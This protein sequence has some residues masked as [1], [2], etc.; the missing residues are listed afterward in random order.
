MIKVLCFGD[1]NTWGYQANSGQRF[2][3]EQRWP[4]ILASLIGKHAQVLENGLP[5]RTTYLNADEYGFHSGIED[6]L[7]ELNERRPDWL[8]IML[9]T[10]DLFP[11]FDLN[12][13]QVAA[14]LEQMIIELSEHCAQHQLTQPKLLILA[15]P[16]INRRGNFAK[17][18]RGAELPSQRLAAYY[19]R[20]ADVFN[21]EFLD[22]AKHITAT[23]Q[24]GVHMDEIQHQ[25]LAEAVA[26]KLLSA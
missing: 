4:G 11:E 20:L 18:F 5:G 6:L 13:Q 9:G 12:A 8:I 16:A 23:L 15:P 22:A 19:Q 25:A 10:N 1:S 17:L 26:E 3:K 24:D 14:N 2:A 7:T 21:C